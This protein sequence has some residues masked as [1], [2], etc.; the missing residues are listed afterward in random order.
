MFGV[1]RTALAL[2]VVAF[3][4]LNIPVIGEYA[5]FSFFVL[6][7]FLMTTIMHES[8][9]Y[10]ISGRRRY[11]LNR[12][13]RIYPSYWV[14]AALTLAVVY[15]CG[16]TFVRSYKNEI[17][18]PNHASSIFYNVILMFPRLF[19]DDVMPRL[20]PPTWALTVEITYYIAIGIGISKTRGITLIWLA[21]SVVYVLA[22]FAFHLGHRYRY[23]AIPA[24]SLPFAIGSCV[25]FYKDVI[26]RQ[27][28]RVSLNLLPIAAG[29]LALYV[30]FSI[31]AYLG[32]SRIAEMGLYIDVAAAALLLVRLYFDGVPGLPRWLDKLVGDY[33]YPIYLLHWPLGALSSYLLFHR[34][35]LGASRSSLAVFGL[36]LLLVGAAGS[37]IIFVI[38]PSIEKVRTRIRERTRSRVA[39]ATQAVLAS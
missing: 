37:F 21:A 7:G 31:A 34:P 28:D 13:L 38:D 14:V 8:Y 16:E 27:L 2:C 18:I 25:Y 11:A 35:E 26:I 29:F 15:F 32:H 39:S 6:S 4:L 23:A 20:S 19:P 9:G 30:V 12:F 24:G 3:H 17:F 5:V 10:D 36:D 22:T 1:W 33:S